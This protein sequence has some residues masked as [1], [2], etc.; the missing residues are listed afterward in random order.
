M[1]KERRSYS[2]G[3]FRAE[4]VR[5]MANGCAVQSVAVESEDP[6]A[7]LAAA[8]RLRIDGFENLSYPAALKRLVGMRPLP[9][10]DARWL[11]SWES[12]DHG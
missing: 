7:V 10:A 5:L 1:R 4:W 3:P 6:A 2:G 9:T 12:G 8:R 11:C